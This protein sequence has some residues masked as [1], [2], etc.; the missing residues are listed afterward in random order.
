[1]AEGDIPK[2]IKE[3]TRVNTKD[4][5]DNTK[6]AELGDITTILEDAPTE[7]D[8]VHGEEEDIRDNT[9]VVEHKNLQNQIG[10]K[11]TPNLPK[12]MKIKTTSGQTDQPFSG[13]T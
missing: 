13:P 11:S 12:K 5:K 1:M 2:D 8:G 9:K 6:G 4:I 3:V 10:V 7:V